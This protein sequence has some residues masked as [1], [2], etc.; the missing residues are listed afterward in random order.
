MFGATEK[1]CIT[2]EYVH[3]VAAGA[4]NRVTVLSSYGHRYDKLL[5]SEI[6]P[7]SKNM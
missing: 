4:K 3:Y 2:P 6:M 7:L 5:Q 1:I